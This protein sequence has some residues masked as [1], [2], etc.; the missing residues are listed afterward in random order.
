[1]CGHVDARMPMRKPGIYRSQANNQKCCGLG[2]AWVVNA[3]STVWP[4]KF[5]Y[6]M[7]L[8]LQAGHLVIHVK[9]RVKAVMDAMVLQA[10]ARVNFKLVLFL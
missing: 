1:M 6:P 3:C 4:R 8:S 7:G 10:S 2:H 5:W 9:N